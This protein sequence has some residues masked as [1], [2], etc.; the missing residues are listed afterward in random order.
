MQSL[1]LAL[2]QKHCVV[3]TEASGEGIPHGEEGDL[4]GKSCSQDL[5]LGEAWCLKQLELLRG[6][7]VS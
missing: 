7:P 4:F 1:A 6:H 3:A 2:F 5:R